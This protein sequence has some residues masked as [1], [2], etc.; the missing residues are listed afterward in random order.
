MFTNV[1][2]F[3][4]LVFCVILLNRLYNTLL[5]MIKK[6][7]LERGGGGTSGTPRVGFMTGAGGEDD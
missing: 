4:S 3:L 1:F 5:A 2:F 6:P 7:V